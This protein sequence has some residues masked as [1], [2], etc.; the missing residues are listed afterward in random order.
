[1]PP[2]TRGPQP[3]AGGIAASRWPAESQTFRPSRRLGLA[4]VEPAP[5]QPFQTSGSRSATWLR[6]P[7]WLAFTQETAGPF[8]EILD[9]RQRV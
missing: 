2:E 4:R 7:L 5:P 6:L 3:D 8:L 1:M 9:L